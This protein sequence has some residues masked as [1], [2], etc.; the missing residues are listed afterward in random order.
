[1][2]DASPFG[3]ESAVENLKMYKLPGNDQITAEPIQAGEK[4]TD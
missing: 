4:I 3:T 1:V 2:P